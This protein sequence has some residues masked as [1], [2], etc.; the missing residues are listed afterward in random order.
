M[1]QPQQIL[2]PPQLPGGAGN[3]MPPPPPAPGM[4]PPPS[5]SSWNGA[6]VPSPPPP[7]PPMAGLSKAASRGADMSS[8]PFTSPTA[9]MAKSGS[10]AFV[11]Q[12]GPPIPASA[13]SPGAQP[14]D[15]LAPPDMGTEP[16]VGSA[17]APS[18]GGGI[19]AIGGF[20]SSPGAV[21]NTSA[22]GAPPNGLTAPPS[23]KSPGIPNPSWSGG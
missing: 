9:G 7:P 20:L 5:M 22:P 4:M 16:N 8:M 14:Y 3:T 6:A 18:F 12:F 21:Q 19:G 23:S 1:Q 17:S 13:T 2:P 11:S 10:T 15:P